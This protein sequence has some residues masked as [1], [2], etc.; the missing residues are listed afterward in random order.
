MLDA[1]AWNQAGRE[2]FSMRIKQRLIIND[3]GVH[4]ALAKPGDALF[5][6]LKNS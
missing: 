5:L 4:F 1:R 2:A 6:F 3:I